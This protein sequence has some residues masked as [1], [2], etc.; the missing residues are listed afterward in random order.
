MIMEGNFNPGFRISLHHKD[1]HNALLTAKELGVPLP[2]TSLVQQMLG[3]LI[4]K[5]RGDRD[6]SA[7]VTF[8]EDLANVEAR[9]G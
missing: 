8:I 3:A 6:H 9:K 7:I 5:A 4:N 1:L 2:V